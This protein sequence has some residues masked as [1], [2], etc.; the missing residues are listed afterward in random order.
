MI[1]AK[2][3]D[4]VVSTRKYSSMQG[5]KLLAVEECTQKTLLIAGDMLG[6][7]IGEYVLVSCGEP[8][9]SAADKQMPA[10]AMVVGIIDHKPQFITD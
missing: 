6:A 7:G 2:V 8:A 3:I 9:V 5:I 1:I 4:N 10:D